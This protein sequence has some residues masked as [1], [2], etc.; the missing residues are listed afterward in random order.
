MRTKKHKGEVKEIELGEGKLQL[1]E[2]S[3]WGQVEEN[4]WMEKGGMAVRVE[5]EISEIVMF[6]TWPF[7]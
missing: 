6:V 5:Q 2:N 1:E 4:V 3:D 7:H